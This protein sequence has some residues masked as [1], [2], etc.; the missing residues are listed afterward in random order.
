MN[1]KHLVKQ[2]LRKPPM[3]RRPTPKTLAKKDPEKVPVVWDKV[4]RDEL[5]L[6]RN[7]DRMLARVRQ[8]SGY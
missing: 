4:F 1:S 5:A 8:L 2:E 3:V 6:E 7:M